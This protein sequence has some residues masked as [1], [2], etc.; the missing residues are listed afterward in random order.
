MVLTLFFITDDKYYFYL[1][2]YIKFCEYNESKISV[3][4]GYY[5][6]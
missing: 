3:V 1:L 5:G 6:R 4:R 2:D